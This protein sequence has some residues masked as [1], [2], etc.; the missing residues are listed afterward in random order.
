MTTPRPRNPRRA[1]LGEVQ[2]LI[3]RT[4]I[5]EPEW[6][7]AQVHRFVKSKTPKEADW[8]SLRTVQREVAAI[9]I[10]PRQSD[11]WS[12]FTEPDSDVAALAFP[13]LRVAAEESYEHRFTVDEARFV[14]T[15]RQA[16][17]DVAPRVAYW[18]A[19]FANR[20]RPGVR[21]DVELWLA[22]TPWRDGGEALA[23]AIDLG[24]VPAYASAF[25]TR[26][27]APDIHETL[28]AARAARAA[29]DALELRTRPR[30]RSTR[31]EAPDGR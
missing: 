14:A 31:L 2:S 11:D 4:A 21:E 26:L 1:L 25:S 20:T 6:S 29:E 16:F 27:E 28:R 5:A 19:W 3:R 18:A 23:A 8:P 24:I 15:I 10:E 9:R 22:Y 12:P 7:P 13:V 17:P 30:M